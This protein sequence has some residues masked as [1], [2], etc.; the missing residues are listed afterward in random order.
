MS[1]RGLDEYIL[2]ASKVFWDES[3]DK[4]KPESITRVYRILNKQPPARRLRPHQ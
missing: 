3:G 2:Y 4:T 1:K